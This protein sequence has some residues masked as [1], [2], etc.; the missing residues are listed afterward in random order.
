MVADRESSELARLLLQTTIE[1]QAADPKRLTIHS[2]R[3]SSMTS[4]LVAF[5]LAD[6]DVT[7]SHSRPHVCNDNPHAESL[8]KTT[9]YQPEFP[10][11]FAALAESRAFC[12]AFFGWC[13][14]EDRHSGIALLTPSDV[15]HA[16]AEERYVARQ[17]ILDVAY[18]AHPE[19]FVTADRDRFN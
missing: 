4:K 1:Q 2:D 17:A 19:R 6:L 8:F 12:V 11:I 10:V 3:G 16:R 7:K 5:R 18:A 13:S 14:N 9:R 15:H